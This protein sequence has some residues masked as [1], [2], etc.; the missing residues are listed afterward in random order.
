MQFQIGRRESLPPAC[1]ERLASYRHA[2]FVEALGWDLPCG[3]GREEDAFD[4]DDTVYV[5]AEDEAGRIGAFARLIPTTRAYPLA[6]LF[7][8]LLGQRAAP[9]A[10]DVW[11]LSR[12]CATGVNF[13]RESSVGESMSSPLAIALLR[14]ALLAGHRQGASRLITVSPLG[15]ESLL[16]KA[17]FR[18]GRFAGPQRMGGKRWVV[19]DI[20]VR[21]NLGVSHAAHAQPLA[22][23]VPARSRGLPVVV[24]AGVQPAFA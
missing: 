18:A 5:F 12:F 9:C 17:G 19:C 10:A 13:S 3:S 11:E 15:I 6:Q 23:S 1:I 20:E 14:H 8:A 24:S 21:N 22:P 7:P 16:R 4:R 2:V